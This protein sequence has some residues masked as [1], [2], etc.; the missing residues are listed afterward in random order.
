MEGNGHAS[1]TNQITDELGD[2]ILGERPPQSGVDL[3][4]RIDRCQGL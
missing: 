3:S 4:T 1:L 2:P